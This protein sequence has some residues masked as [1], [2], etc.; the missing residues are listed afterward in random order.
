MVGW[1]GP[2]VYMKVG[3]MQD[4]HPYEKHAMDWTV[5]NPCMRAEASKSLS[6]L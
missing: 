6:R 3:E 4:I 2:V 1:F 5:I